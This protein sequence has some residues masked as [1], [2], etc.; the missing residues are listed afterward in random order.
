MTLVRLSSDRAKVNS[1]RAEAAWEGFLDWGVSMPTLS[2]ELP[3]SGSS[4][5]SHWPGTS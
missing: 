4:L 2:P 3:R 5:A 1:V